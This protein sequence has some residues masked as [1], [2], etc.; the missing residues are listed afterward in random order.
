MADSK[1][2]SP[3]AIAGVVYLTCRFLF[4]TD[5]C[6]TTW[7]SNRDARN[8]DTELRQRID[9]L[10]LRGVI[11]TREHRLLEDRID[12]YYVNELVRQRTQR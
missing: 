11:S 7:M 10:H 3:L 8:R 9:D 6:V 1:H 5:G 12:A 2:L 4:G